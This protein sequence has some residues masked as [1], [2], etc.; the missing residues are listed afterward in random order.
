M[1]FIRAVVQKS[2]ASYCEILSGQL[3]GK[4]NVGFIGV[5]LQTYSGN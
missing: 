5:A 1:G 3:L 2:F 4:T